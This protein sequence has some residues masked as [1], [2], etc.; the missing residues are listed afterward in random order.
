MGSLTTPLEKKNKSWCLPIFACLPPRMGYLSP[1][2]YTPFPWTSLIRL[3]PHSKT[4]VD[5]LFFG[6]VRRLWLCYLFSVPTSG[7]LADYRYFLFLISWKKGII[8]PIQIISAP[9][10]SNYFDLS[11]S[12]LTDELL[13]SILV[14]YQITSEP[15]FQSLHHNSFRNHLR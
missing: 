8:P 4:I 1:L 5:T 15:R 13:I 12:I 9:S 3:H 6:F 11:P 7:H 10:F 14:H 2:P